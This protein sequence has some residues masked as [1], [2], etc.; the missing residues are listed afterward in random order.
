MYSTDHVDERY[1]LSALTGRIIAAAQEVQNT[2]GPGFEEKVYQ[3]ALA[4]ELPAQGLEYSWEVW[5]EVHYKGE[6]VGEKRID[7][8]I[9][10][11][12]GAVMVEIKAKSKL[13]VCWRPSGFPQRLC[14]WNCGYQKPKSGQ[15]LDIKTLRVFWVT[16]W[17]Y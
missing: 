17:G 10:D 16:R 5:I 12:T 15:P 4:L 6:I 13:E 14:I 9:D 11:P 2:L 8:L 3:R 1:S 7:F